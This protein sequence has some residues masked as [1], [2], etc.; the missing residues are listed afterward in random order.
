MNVI[1]KFESFY[2]DLASMKVEELSDIYSD[3]VV[4][5]DP[6]AHH[7]GIS[8]VKQYFGKLLLDAQYCTFSIHSIDAMKS[9]DKDPERSSDSSKFIVC[10]KMTF[11]SPRINKG[12]PIDVDGITEL[13]TKDNKIYYHRDYY[14]LGQMVYEN[15]PLLGRI[16]KSIKRKLG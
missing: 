11:T 8:S 9:S 14:D 5:I 16:I 3:D 13:K 2:T 12:K 6:I 4:F 15:V 7:L 10:W 1:T